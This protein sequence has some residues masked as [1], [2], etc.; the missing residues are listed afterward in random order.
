MRDRWPPLS[1]RTKVQLGERSAQH[2]EPL[3]RSGYE[4]KVVT[5]IGARPQFIKAAMV[6]RALRALPE[7]EETVVHTGQH[8]DDDMS[9]VFVEELGLP[10]RDYNLEIGSRHRATRR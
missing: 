9:A 6:S 4:L 8:C 1:S 5:I 10:E 7:V 2:F 3:P